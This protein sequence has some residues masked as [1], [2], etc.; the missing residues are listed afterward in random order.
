MKS[1]V[2]LLLGKMTILKDRIK[3]LIIKE[4][5]FEKVNK[6][7]GGKLALYAPMPLIVTDKIFERDIP[8]LEPVKRKP[9]KRDD[10]YAIM[11]EEKYEEKLEEKRITT[12]EQKPIN[13]QGVPLIITNKIEEDL[14]VIP[15]DYEGA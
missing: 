7:C 12:D 5:Y 13:Y 3:Y 14:F 4:D 6:E 10:R 15:R 9:N 8:I 1:D 2:M 11:H